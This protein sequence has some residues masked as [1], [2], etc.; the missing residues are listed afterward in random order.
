VAGAA[1][2]TE[3]QAAHAERV[4]RLAETRLEL[5]RV[6]GIEQSARLEE[7]IQLVTGAESAP[8][9]R[10]ALE[11]WPDKPG[12]FYAEAF[13]L[14]RTDPEFLAAHRPALFA[15]FEGDNHVD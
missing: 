5:E 6:T 8:P 4:V 15:W 11:S 3:L 13:A 7:F 9:T 2:I 12:E 1:R 14:Y 10:Y